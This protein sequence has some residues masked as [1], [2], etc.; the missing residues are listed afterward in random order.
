MQSPPWSLVISPLGIQ[1]CSF[2]AWAPEVA[3]QLP[4]FLLQEEG[5]QAADS[6]A[7]CKILTLISV[8]SLSHMG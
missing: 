1:C 6:G 7:Q 5:D 4:A 3:A 8:E 2:P